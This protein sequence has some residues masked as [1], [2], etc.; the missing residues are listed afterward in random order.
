MN[1]NNI[2]ESV[3][4]FAQKITPRIFDIQMMLCM[5]TYA[6]LFYVDEDTEENDS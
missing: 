6:C 1:L 4:I 2:F 3:R 5:C